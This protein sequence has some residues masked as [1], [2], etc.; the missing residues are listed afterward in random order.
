MILESIKVMKSF[1]LSI[2]VINTAFFMRSS[3]FIR[4]VFFN[5]NQ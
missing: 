3:S 1:F 2:K 5:I 4:L